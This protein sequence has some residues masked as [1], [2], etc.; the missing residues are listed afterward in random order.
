MSQPLT[1][2]LV[3]SRAG[4]EE[5]REELLTAVYAELRRLASKQLKRGP[6]GADLQPTMLVHDAF[7]H[8][9]GRDEIEWEGR[10][11]FFALAAR[12]MRELIIQQVR[13][14]QALK[15]GGQ[16]ARQELHSDVVQPQEAEEDLLALNTALEQLEGQQSELARVIDL[17]FFCGFSREEAATLI[18]ISPA[19][20]DRR[21]SEA[22][23]WLRR[24][25]GGP[26]IQDA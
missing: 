4:S 25:M 22:K 19:T 3:R 1:A 6:Q 13:R 11:H 15:R 16:W 17:R 20:L 12:A 24:Q 10:S 5:A 23:G 7:L 9:V 14:D 18:G 21:W 2:L 8:L 26:E